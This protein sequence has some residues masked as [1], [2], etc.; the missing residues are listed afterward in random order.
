[1]LPVPV[2]KTKYLGC[3]GYNASPEELGE[4]SGFWH[5]E[6]HQ[7]LWHAFGISEALNE[8][9]DTLGETTYSRI[10]MATDGDGYILF[11]LLILSV[12][13]ISRELEAHTIELIKTWLL[14]QGQDWRLPESEWQVEDE[15]NVPRIEL[16]F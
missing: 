10:V 13:F 8:A 11:H 6:N 2:R 7:K 15:A 12:Q 14:G 5:F 9:F 1:M 4:P 3:F 16:P